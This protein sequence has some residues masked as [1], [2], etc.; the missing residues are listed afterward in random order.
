[1]SEFYDELTP[2]YHLIFS[3]WDASMHRQGEQLATIIRSEWA[4]I[5]TVLDVS[6]GIGTQAIPLARLGFSVSGSD[7]SPRQVERAVFEAKKRAQPISFS[8]CDMREASK[9]H[10]SGWD[11]VMSC[12][13]SMPHLLTDLDISVALGQMFA[14]LRPGG[15]CL[16][17]MRDYDKE[18]RGRNVFKP[19]GVRVE[20]N[21]RY[22]LFQVW[23]FAGEH[24]DL[25]LY[26]VEDTLSIGAVEVRA[27]RSR[28]YA[29]GTDRMIALMERTGFEAIKRLD[30]VF[31]QPV[32]VGTKPRYARVIGHQRDRP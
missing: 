25:T 31:Y 16:V 27:M 30:Q 6:C 13:N 11:L 12:D 14:C 28:C 19:Y 20:S 4:G 21:K 7:S 18:E 15:G 10:G 2:F 5:K 22:S 8:V 17:T 26:V 24:Y 29:I 32:L 3:D 23:D 1:M 9:R